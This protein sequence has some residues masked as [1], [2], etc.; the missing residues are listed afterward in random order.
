MAYSS[1]GLLQ[2]QVVYKSCEK[3]KAGEVMKSSTGHRVNVPGV[4]T[5]NKLP[6]K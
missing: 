3:K 6:G 5:S 1:A 4:A 2:R